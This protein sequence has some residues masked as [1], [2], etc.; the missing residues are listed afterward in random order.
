[1]STSFLD[2]LFTPAECDSVSFNGN[3]AVVIDVLRASTTMVTALAHGCPE[4]LPVETVEDAFSLAGQFPRHGILLGGERDGKR[5]DGFDLGNSPRD[6]TPER[7]DGRLLIMTTTNGTRALLKTNTAAQVYVMALLNLQA[8]C[9]RLQ[10]RRRDT[11]VV[12]AG[13]KGEHSL[14]DSVAAGLLIDRLQA[15]DQTNWTLGEGAHQALELALTHKSDLLA[16][17]QSSPHGA[18]LM[19]IGFGMDLDICARL[20][21]C[22]LVP[23]YESGAVRV[24]RELE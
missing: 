4:I 7:L 12:C 3:A 10:R 20:N 2:V 1:M 22:D 18:Y 9:E 23:I 6:Y 16:M 14:E 13:M 5:V 19:S 15:D 24:F 17:L 21:A 11:L 8:V